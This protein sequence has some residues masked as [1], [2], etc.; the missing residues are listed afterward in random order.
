MKEIVVISGKGG[1]GKTSFAAG[2]SRLTGKNAV[3]VDADVDAADL[4]LLMDSKILKKN[5]FKGLPTPVVDMDKCTKCGKCVELCRFDA[6]SPDIKID[7]LLCEGCQVC[8]NFCPEEAISL[9]ECPMGE[10][11]V[12]ETPYGPLVHA[13]LD[14]GGENSGLLV[15][16]VRKSGKALARDMKKDFIITDGPPGIGCSVISSLTGADFVCVVVE[17]TVSGVHDMERVMELVDFLDIPSAVLINKY[18]LNLAACSS[19]EEKLGQ[20]GIPVIGKFPYD[21][22]FYRAILQKKTIPD[23]KDVTPY[24]HDSFEKAWNHLV[25][26][27]SKVGQNLS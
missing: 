2:F 10:W 8:Y 4:S 6:I 19:L 24:I 21:E 14:P 20:Q 22:V 23:M 25:S 26:L 11:Y 27:V 5:E 12:S 13:K 16:I 15:S 9:K 17:A 3:L 1:A 18:D 7:T